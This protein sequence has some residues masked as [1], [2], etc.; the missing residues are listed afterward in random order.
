MLI[1]ISRKYENL[2]FWASPI[3][4][5]LRK[6]FFSNYST[7]TILFAYVGVRIQLRRTY[8]LINCIYWRPFKWVESNFVVL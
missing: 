3:L 8:D 2:L 5:K 1:L 4:L 7:N 6:T